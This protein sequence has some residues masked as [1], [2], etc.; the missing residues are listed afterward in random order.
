MA[1]RSGT[2]L[3]TAEQQHIVNRLFACQEPALS[4]SNR[5]IFTTLSIE[6]L[7]KKFA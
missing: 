1:V 6:E 4:P 5:T 2:L 3:N 7:D